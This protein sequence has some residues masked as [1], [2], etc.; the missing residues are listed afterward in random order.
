MINKRD[1]ESAVKCI[2]DAFSTREVVLKSYI[3]SINKS[4]DNLITSF[5]DQLTNY[6]KEFTS[7]HDSFHLLSNSVDLEYNNLKEKKLS[8]IRQLFADSKNLCQALKHVQENPM[9]WTLSKMNHMIAVYKT[10]N[11]RARIQKDLRI[12][13]TTFD[14]VCETAFK[15]FKSRSTMQKK[16]QY[17]FQLD[18]MKE[19]IF[20]WKKSIVS[21]SEEWVNSLLVIKDNCSIEYLEELHL[22]LSDLQNMRQN[23]DLYKMKLDHL[24]RSSALGLDRFRHHCRYDEDAAQ[25]MVKHHNGSSD[26]SKDAL[27]YSHPYSIF[28]HWN[29]GEG[30]D[31]HGSKVIQ[32]A[33][34]ERC[35]MLMGTRIRSLGI[36][37]DV[38]LEQ[39]EAVLIDLIRFL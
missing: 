28:Y 3:A 14:R 16:D 6:R 15:I 24:S 25:R 34:K 36:L 13:D 38:S 35:K 4:H 39:V 30:N 10:P 20:N 7:S 2:D 21:S 9:A 18:D 19:A 32:P 29:G 37:A 5:R 26:P 31:D 17:I 33:E 1:L 8:A 23:L 12:I 11:F 27:I 22:Q